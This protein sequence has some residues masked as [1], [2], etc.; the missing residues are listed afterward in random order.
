M[1]VFY[2]IQ[3][4]RYL[5][6]LYSDDYTNSESSYIIQLTRNRL[7][8]LPKQLTYFREETFSI[9]YLAQRKKERKRNT[10]EEREKER[11]NVS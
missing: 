4:L 11:E 3:L 10:E 9:I 8:L 7:Y 1:L 5:A 6:I 2:F